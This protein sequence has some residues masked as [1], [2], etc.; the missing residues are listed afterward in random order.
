METEKTLRDEFA[1]A[2]LAGL[3]AYPG[4]QGED[5]KPEHFARWAYYLAD[6]MLAERAAT[7]QTPEG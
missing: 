3:V 1:M 4:R 2:A 6:A 5:N 7:P